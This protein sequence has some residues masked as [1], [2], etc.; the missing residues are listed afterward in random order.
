MTDSER[1]TAAS[2]G[3]A[4]KRG[5]RRLR[6]LPKIAVSTLA[7]AASASVAHNGVP[8]W[9]ATLFE[10]LHDVPRA[11]DHVLWLPMQAGSAWAPPVVALIAWRLTRS[12]RPTLGELVTGWGGWWMAK[13]VKN[14]IERGRP[15]AELPEQMVRSSAITEG[16]GFVSGHA[17]VAF[18]CAATLSPYLSSRWRVFGYGLATTV[19]VSRVVVG[20]HLPMDLVGGAALGLTLAYVWHLA[21]GIDSSAAAKAAEA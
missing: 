1:A 20:A 4:T 8:D 18:A 11:V 21:V 3:P 12:W 2:T 6:Q 10:W 19:G 14:E 9:E 17:T 13:L 5:T 16:L 7:L 15:S